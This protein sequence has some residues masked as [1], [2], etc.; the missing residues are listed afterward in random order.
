LPGGL[1]QGNQVIAAAGEGWGREGGSGQ[2]REEH[3][4]RQL[5][6]GIGSNRPHGIP[7]KDIAAWHGKA[8]IL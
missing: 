7:E 2:E 6:A 8:L 5:P 3:S 4:R 1:A